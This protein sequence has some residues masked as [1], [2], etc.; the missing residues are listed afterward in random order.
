[1]KIK[2]YYLLVFLA[3][4][5]CSED[6]EESDPT[7]NFLFYEEEFYAVS[8]GMT[9]DFG[10]GSSHYN[11]DFYLTDGEAFTSE[12]SRTFTG[13]SYI[14]YLEL[15]SNG[16]SKF[17]TGEFTF[18]SEEQATV[19]NIANKNWFS[20]IQWR[21]IE[22]GDVILGDNIENGIVTVSGEEENYTLDININF[23]DGAALKGNYS[24][25]LLSSTYL[26][27]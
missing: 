2:Y 3:L 18:I 16:T 19:E 17:N 5:S 11:Y 20:N 27:K 15:F 24:L 23:K 22:E 25:G 26:Q 7:S 4:F 21:T 1:M 13:F 8:E 14:F 12:S 6:D 10:S 9:V